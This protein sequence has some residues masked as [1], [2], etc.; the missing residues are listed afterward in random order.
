MNNQSTAI[1][2]PLAAQ[3]FEQGTATLAQ[4]AKKA[5]LSIA[6]FLEVLQNFDIDA[7][8]HAPNEMDDDLK[9]MAWIRA[10]EKE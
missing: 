1:R 8:C 7:V 6:E 4:A 10:G 2:V 9:A 3:L 5:S